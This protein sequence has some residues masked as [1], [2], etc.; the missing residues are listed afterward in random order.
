VQTV[1][2]V[3]VD[4]DATAGTHPALERALNL[5]RRWG[6]RLR[7]VDVVHLPGSALRYLRPRMQ[8]QLVSERRERLVEIQRG[9]TGLD[10]DIDV[11]VGRPAIALIQEVLRSNHDLLIRS[12]VRDL[13][14]R[15][16][17]PYDSVG[18]QLFRDCPCP[19]LAVGLGVA[20][21]PPRV[22]A[23]VNADVDD[24][25][26]QSLNTKLLELG[27]L[28]TETEGGS[29]TI[30]QAWAPFAASMVRTRTTAEEFTAYLE[31]TQDAARAG[32]KILTGPF[33][34]RLAGARIEL[35]Q[36]EPED[37]I[38]EFVVAEGIDLVVM[39]TVARTGI[40]GLLIGNTAERLLRRLPCSVLAVKPDG[41]RSPVHPA[42]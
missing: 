32:L 14:V 31:Q 8:E 15:E 7:I 21:R 22:L 29:L 41:F 19:V 38:P 26:E 13:A 39:G 2:S 11:L 42:P 5:A 9:T 28:V 10:I 35:R 12:H 16:S 23:A 20:R 25:V 18:M 27:L 4:I 1:K 24:A 40:A 6:A 17:R 37:V 33:G 34:A 36:G 30:L 3:L